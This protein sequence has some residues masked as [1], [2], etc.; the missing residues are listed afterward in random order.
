M[1]KTIILVSIISFAVVLIVL[2]NFLYKGGHFDRVKKTTTI[3]TTIT[4]TKSQSTTKNETIIVE[5]KGAVNYPGIYEFN[6]TEVRIYEVIEMA[7][8]LTPLA[9]TDALNLAEIVENNSSIY[10]SKSVD[11]DSYTIKMG[12]VKGKININTASLSELMSLS[13]IGERKAQSIITYRNTNGFFKNIEEL[14]NVDGIGDALFESIK[15]DIT[16]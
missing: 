6:R 7:G 2:F 15:E 11:S 13:G 5:I 16:V 1:K 3:E 9:N 8:G 14:K 4:T 10:I 12:T